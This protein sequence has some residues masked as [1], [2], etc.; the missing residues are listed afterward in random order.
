MQLLGMF[1]QVPVR[2]IEGLVAGTYTTLVGETQ[3]VLRLWFNPEGFIHGSLSAEGET[4]EVRGG[5][6]E[7]HGA[8]YGLLL[9]RFGHI[10]MAVFSAQLEGERLLLKLGAPEFEQLLEACDSKPI[11]FSRVVLPEKTKGIV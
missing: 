9:E 5:F 4:F 6:S 7:R 1:E 10:P 3:C 2:L 11:P 8:M